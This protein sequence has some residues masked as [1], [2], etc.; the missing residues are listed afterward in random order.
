[1][2]ERVGER[3]WRQIEGN[4]SREREK[5]D[6]SS[7]NELAFQLLL[8]EHVFDSLRSLRDKGNTGVH[9]QRA[10][11]TERDCVTSM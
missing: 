2:G 8:P 3:S 4:I 11:G 10:R 5:R 1:M 9:R 6:A 7:A